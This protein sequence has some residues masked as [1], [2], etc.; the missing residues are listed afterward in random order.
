MRA[1]TQLVP[2]ARSSVYTGGGGSVQGGGI[3]VLPQLIERQRASNVKENNHHNIYIYI[4][5]KET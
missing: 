2:R 3:A 4:F 1:T 5:K